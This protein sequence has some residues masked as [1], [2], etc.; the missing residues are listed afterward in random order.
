MD[1]IL[2]IYKYFRKV[3]SFKLKISSSMKKSTI[4]MLKDGTNEEQKHLLPE[5][6]QRFKKV[7]S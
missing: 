2:K 3:E 7:S 1:G 4:M 6:Y 5:D